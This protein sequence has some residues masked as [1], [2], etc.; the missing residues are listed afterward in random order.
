MASLRLKVVYEVNTGLVMNPS[1]LMENYL[2]GVPTCT[3]DG[4]R[5]SREAI[6]N[7]IINAQTTLENLFSIKLTKTVISENRD[8][9]CN[10]WNSWGFVRMM[11]PINYVHYLYGFINTVLQVKYP[12]E[13]LSIKRTHC[14]ADYRNLYLIPNSGSGT[15][16]TGT[17]NSLVFHGITPNLGWFGNAFIPNYWHSMYI[18]GWDKPP[19]D[20]LDVIA[21]LAAINILAILG[22]I[23]YG[24]GVSSIQMSLDGVSQSTPLTRS[25]QGGIFAGRMKQYLEDINRAMETMK[26]NYRGITFEVV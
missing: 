21:K 24:V 1:E 16:A 25:A 9:N 17:Y 23:L 20:L 2:F 7:Q 8:Y 18:T 3:N 10:E 6:T 5:M 4:R 11:Y 15:G 19:R 13:W 12:K 26:Y 14:I 22:D